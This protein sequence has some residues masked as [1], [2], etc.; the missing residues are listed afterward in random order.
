MTQRLAERLLFISVGKTGKVLGYVAHPNSQ[1][2][3]EFYQEKFRGVWSI[4]NYR[5]TSKY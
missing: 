1:I 4:F 5:I 3:N 2:A